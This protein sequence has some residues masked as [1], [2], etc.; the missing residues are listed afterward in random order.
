[1]QVTCRYLETQGPYITMPLFKIPKH[2]K[3]K[4]VL[5]LL[6]GIVIFL[7]GSI[8]LS[9]NC[10]WKLTELLIAI[11]ATIIVIIGII[12]SCFG[13]LYILLDISN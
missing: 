2:K 8:I 1:M 5:K 13:L 9:V 6:F 11:P 10:E 7:I 12:Q 4:G 3:V